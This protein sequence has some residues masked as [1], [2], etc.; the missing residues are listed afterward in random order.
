MNKSV[1]NENF[2]DSKEDLETSP[3]TPWDE[4]NDDKSCGIINLFNVNESSKQSILERR[5]KYHSPS[6]K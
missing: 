4:I 2:Q 6:K 1:E 5:Q 3:M